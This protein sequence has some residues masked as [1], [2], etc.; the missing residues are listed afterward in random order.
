MKIIS[1]NVNGVRAAVNKGLLEFLAMEN[2]DVVCL[3]EIKA[4]KDQVNIEAI[5][6]LGYSH[7]FWFSAEK[8]GYS[9]VSIWSKI[10]PEQIITGCDHPLFDAEGR[11]IAIKIDD[12]YIMSV[13]FPSGT[14]GDIRQDIKYRFLDY[15]FGYA[16]LLKD[17]GL[18][19]I[20]CG[21]YNICHKEIDIHDP[22]GNKNSS[23]FLPDEREWMEKWFNS[24]FIDSFRKLNQEPH[25]YT[26]WTFRA[27]ARANNKGWRIDYISIDKHWDSQLKGAGILPEAK[28]SDHCPIWV[29]L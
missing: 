18:K 3:Q 25:H 20:I 2:P 16:Q 22:K 8:K 9:G 1:Y 21:D 23:G 29:E 17:K 12:Y 24:G 19:P 7:H 13:Y 28:H 15:F 5:E 27:N 4:E 11:C 26:W 14:T 10:K 6:K